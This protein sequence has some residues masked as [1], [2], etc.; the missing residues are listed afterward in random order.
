MF[1][2][3]GNGFTYR[4]LNMASKSL[5][6]GNMM[7]L[8]ATM[9]ATGIWQVICHVSNHLSDGMQGLYQVY[10]KASCPLDK[11]ASK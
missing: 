2:M 10:P 4:G 3:H 6:D 9:Y 11:L 8:Q 5:N 1:H 7:T